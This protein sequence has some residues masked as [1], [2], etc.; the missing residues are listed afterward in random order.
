MA[1]HSHIGDGLADDIELDKHWQIVNATVAAFAAAEWKIPEDFL[2]YTHFERVILGLDWNSSPGYPYLLKWSTNRDMFEVR[3]GKPSVAAKQRAWDMVM[4]RLLVEDA[5]PVRLFVKPEAHKQSKLDSHRYRLISSVSVIDQI[6]DHMLFGVMNQNM[7]DNY[8]LIPSKVG[9]SPYKG[10]WKIVPA[11]KMVAT[12]KSAWDW[13]VKDWLVK[14]ELAVRIYLCRNKGGQLFALWKR[15]ALFRYNKLYTENIF[16]TSGGDFLRQLQ[17][18]V[19][20]SGCVNT[21]ATNSIMQVLIHHRACIDIDEAPKLLWAMGDDTLQYPQDD[22]QK[23]CKALSNYCMLKEYQM[24]TEF[25]GNEFNIGANVEPL[26]R[27]KHMFNLLHVDPKVA[28]DLCFAYALL[29]HRSKGKDAMTKVLSELGLLVPDEYLDHV[30]D[31][32]W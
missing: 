3:D 10:G 28:P 14:A 9:W 11:G 26:Y 23:Y 4:Q 22:M 30:F 21:I 18:G 25:A 2:E 17:P 12:D 20:K 15:Y 27:A 8:M 1:V 31:G 16:V 6:L 19:V 7:I 5:D 13:T 24:K 32:E 29:Y